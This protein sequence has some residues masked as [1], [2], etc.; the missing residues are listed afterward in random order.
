M[1]PAARR[2]P[3]FV[4]LGRRYVRRKLTRALDGV[5]AAGLGQARD[6]AKRQPIILAANHVGWW[7]SFLV[8]AVD[9][10]L[11]TEGFALMDQSSVERMPYFG[12]QGAVPLD[13]ASPR[14]GLRQGARLLDR[15][16]RALWIFPSGGHRP[17]HLRPL[18]F[19]PGIVLL[20]RMAPAAAVL[21]VAF[22][23]AW[24]DA[25]RPRAWVHVGDPVEV[26]QVE[27][28]VERGLDQIDHALRGEPAG[29]EMLIAPRGRR[30]DQGM[31]ARI[32]AGWRG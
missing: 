14:A 1:T 8:I 5:W 6:V 11:G 32:L 29:F 22:Q 17:A 10:A 7:D 31:G 21:P 16:G 13:Q 27:P 26:S 9:Q 4:A 12:W 25:D 2:S 23:Y 15:P 3:R 28:A 20:A 19:K 24:G 30:P 18:G